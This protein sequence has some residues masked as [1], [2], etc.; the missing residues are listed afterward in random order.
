MSI[1]SPYL[2]PGRPQELVHGGDH[3]TSAAN[4]TPP[5]HRGPAERSVLSDASIFFRAELLIKPLW[6]PAR[7]QTQ[8]QPRFIAGGRTRD[9]GDAPPE[10]LPSQAELIGHKSLPI[11]TD[12]AMCSMVDEISFINLFFQKKIPFLCGFL[13]GFTLK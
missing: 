13:I 6:Q 11:R 8:G 3:A 7:R 9:K 5:P 10:C 4:P 2:L 1:S 12:P